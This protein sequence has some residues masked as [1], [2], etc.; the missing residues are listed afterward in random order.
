M[1]HSKDEIEAFK[2]QINLAEYAQAAG[3]K[4]DKT[5]SSRASTV[6]RQGDD[7]IVVA[8]DQDGHGIY[9]SVRD[10]KDNGSIVD[11]VQKRQG[12]N[13]GQVRKELRSWLEG[14]PSSY[15][16]ELAVG[17]PRKPDPSNSDR[18]RV[19]AVWSRMD[20]Q[21]DGG[22][23]YLTGERALRQETLEDP[24]F[25]GNI[26]IDQRGNAVFPHFDRDGLAGYEL[27]NMDFTGFAK[28]G[29]KALWKSSNINHAK[30]VVIVESAIDALSHSQIAGDRDAAY[31]SIGGAISD[32]QRR[33]LANV[34]AEAYQQ[35]A[36]III[37]TDADQAG[38]RL[39]K[40][41]R[42]EPAVGKDWND[43]LKAKARDAEK[44]R[45]QA[46]S[47]LEAVRHARICNSQYI[48]QPEEFMRNGFDE[49]WRRL[50]REKQQTLVDRAKS[51]RN[52]NELHGLSPDPAMA[53]I[54]AAQNDLFNEIKADILCK[55]EPR[56]SVV[57]ADVLGRAVGL[58]QQ[59]RDGDQQ[60]DELAQSA[61]I[62]PDLAK[63]QSDKQKQ[64]N[65]I[66][67]ERALKAM[68]R[69]VAGGQDPED[70]RAIEAGKD[71]GMQI[72]RE[73]G[74]SGLGLG[75]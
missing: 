33:L 14:I 15:R 43:E 56:D 53:G 69:I 64:G 70:L 12:V 46:L 52:A 23:P 37:G 10:E 29:E 30:R 55:Q 35:G 21:P 7:K 44:R 27:K 2:S 9:F 13:L 22:H 41:E 20:P 8:T 5:E 28:G 75:R 40:I 36:Q 66:V 65:A 60:I 58:A 25:A 39:A 74:S 71:I 73:K 19:L 59:R 62:E 45:Q 67:K 31:I 38:R 17:R 42:Q 54:I 6:M 26:R 4:I 1:T 34:L 68:A 72:G 51:C 48:A 49:Y 3:Y 24:R 11:F 57:W 63:A 61:G 32:K 18:L 16:P 47:L 50:G